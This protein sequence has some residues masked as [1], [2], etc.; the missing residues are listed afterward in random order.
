ML[1]TYQKETLCNFLRN[2]NEY[3]GYKIYNKKQK[4][5]L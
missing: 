1:L 3:Y 4:S 5:P 2:F